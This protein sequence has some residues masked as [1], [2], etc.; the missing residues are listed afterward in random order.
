MSISDAP[1]EK[2]SAR[3]SVALCC[4]WLINVGGA[5]RVLLELHK[6]YPDAPIYTSK[7]SQKGIDWFND[8]DVRTGYLQYFPS[9]LR[10]FIG[11]LRARYFRKLDLTA[12]D[13]VI[14]VTGAEAKGIK[15]K[16]EQG[17]TEQNLKNRTGF[18]T[19]RGKT[20]HICF[21]HVPTQYY[22][23]LYDQYMRDPGFD[24]LNP[25]AR[26]GLKIFVKPMRKRDFEAAKRPDYYVTISEYA[27]QEIKRYYKRESTI[28]YPPVDTKTFVSKKSNREKDYFITTSRFVN[29]KRLD[30]A[31]KAC[32][33]LNKKLI[34]IGEGPEA[35]KLKKLAKGHP[36]IIFLPKMEQK[37]LRKYLCNA[38]AYL[39]PSQEPFGIAPVEALAAGCPVI[40]YQKGGALDYIKDGKNGLFFAEQSVSSLVSALEEF[41]KLKSVDPKK[42]SPTE[43]P[44]SALPFDTEI[45]KAKMQEFVHEKIR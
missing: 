27:K 22:W 28:I 3:L 38:S 43:I 9:C 25:L 8:A 5:E 39:F 19:G 35:K 6:M 32:I 18:S 2:D 34:L 44:A 41:Q 45:F 14:S 33:K 4:D 21:C 36:N 15:T 11:P 1:R 17:K 26:L 31:I 29:W 10:K 7:Y 24:I 40:A 30:L 12:Y 16:V 37:E 23:G 42:F 13:L 20:T